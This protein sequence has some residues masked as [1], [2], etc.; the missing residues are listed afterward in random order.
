MRRLLT[1]VSLVITV[2]FTSSQVVAES[3]TKD[4]IKSILRELQALTHQID[5]RFEQIDKRFEQIDKRFEQIDKRFDLLLWVIGLATV[6]TT[7]VLSYLI[8]RLQRLEDERHTFSLKFS[9]FV[10]MIHVASPQEKKIIRD[11][12]KA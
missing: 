9:D 8:L 3:A 7:G 1:L 10:E 5:K 6:F 2:S 12:L 4:D 11:L